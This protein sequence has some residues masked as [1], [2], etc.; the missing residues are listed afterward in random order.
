MN[1]QAQIVGLVIA[2]IS[3]IILSAAAVMILHKL[4]VFG[5]TQT[6]QWT[7]LASAI[8]KA[9]TIV[10]AQVIPPACEATETV[11]SQQTLNQDT[12]L[13]RRGIKELLTNRPKTYLASRANQYFSDPTNHQQQLEWAFDIAVASELKQCW[14][15]VWHGKIN[16][17]NE[18]D[19][20]NWN[21]VKSWAWNTPNDFEDTAITTCVLCSAIHFSGEQPVNLEKKSVQ[22]FEPFL[23]SAIVPIDR[24]QR[25]YYDYFMQ[26][27]EPNQPLIIT[28]MKDIPTDKSLAVM[29]VHRAK[30]KAQAAKEAFQKIVKE[31]PYVTA[32]VALTSAVLLAIPSGGTSLAVLTTLG[33]AGTGAVAGGIAGQDTATYLGFET[34]SLASIDALDSIE[35]VP[36]KDAALR[37]ERCQL[38][39]S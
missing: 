32:G 11:L 12:D 1:K 22:S 21:I 2:V 28:L 8:A 13:G 6:C 27:A 25:T 31:H 9:S 3:I 17:F 34:P 7:F 16:A 14:D 38:Y 36:Y 39:L 4:E 35:L 23:R 26:S 18:W 33:A 37:R 19:K 15:K 20:K 30:P 10:G 29:Y 5:T 24:L